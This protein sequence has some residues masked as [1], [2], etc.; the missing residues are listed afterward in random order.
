LFRSEVL[1]RTISRVR[2][3]WSRGREPVSETARPKDAA[4]A[5]AGMPERGDLDAI[6]ALT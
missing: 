4:F 1:K 3:D 5:G 2:D 6:R